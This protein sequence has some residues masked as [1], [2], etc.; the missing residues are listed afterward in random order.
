MRPIYYLF[1]IALLTSGLFSACTVLPKPKEA[2]TIYRLSIPEIRLDGS[3]AHKKVVNIEY[4]TAPKALSGTDITVTPDGRRLAVAAN[5]QWAEP[6]PSLL[7]NGLIDVLAANSD[8][9]GI[10]PKG[11]TRVPY[12]LNIDVRRFEAVFD[13]GPDMAPNAVV[14]VTL[15]LTET[16]KR[17]LIGSY[18]IK[19]QKRASTA[20]ISS[21]VEAQD[22]AVRDAMQQA[23][24]WLSEQLS[25]R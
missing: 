25:G 11:N 17:K 7:R 23:S 24:N 14:Q 20:N 4:P 8:V 12:R 2:A 19:T 9:M 16:S 13:G 3:T 5:A 18:F 6:V 15:L 21:I 22:L 10:I 1:P